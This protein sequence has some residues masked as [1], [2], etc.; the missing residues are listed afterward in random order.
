MQRSL[1]QRVAETDSGLLGAVVSGWLSD[2]YWSLQE[3]ASDCR[4][5]VRW[6]V[7]LRGAIPCSDLFRMYGV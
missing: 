6:K 3:T 1:A 5:L 2:R 7:G 4:R